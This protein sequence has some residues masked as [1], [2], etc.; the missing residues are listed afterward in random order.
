MLHAVGRYHKSFVKAYLFQVCLEVELII[1][2]GREGVQLN[3]SNLAET[4][5]STIDNRKK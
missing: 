3:L 1:P 4:Q 5:L 2:W